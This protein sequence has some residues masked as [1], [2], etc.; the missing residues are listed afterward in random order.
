M[1]VILLFENMNLLFMLGFVPVLCCS[2]KREGLKYT[3]LFFSFSVMKKKHK[4]DTIVEAEEE[5]PRTFKREGISAAAT[6]E[7]ILKDKFDKSDMSDVPDDEE[8]AVVI[9]DL[10]DIVHNKEMGFINREIGSANI[11]HDPRLAG[12]SPRCKFAQRR[13]H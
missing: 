5:E 6:C 10:V 12:E 13:Q 2:L 9:V 8:S 3:P 7:E 4:L 1:Q 11:S